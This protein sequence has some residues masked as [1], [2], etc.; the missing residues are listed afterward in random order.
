LHL[1]VLAT[2]FNSLLMLPLKE[3]EARRPS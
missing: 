2:F 1:A 3:P